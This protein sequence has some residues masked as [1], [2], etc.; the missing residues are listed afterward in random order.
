MSKRYAFIEAEKRCHT[1][2]K[3]CRVVRVSPS[4]Y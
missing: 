4:A 3:L 2:R 1:T